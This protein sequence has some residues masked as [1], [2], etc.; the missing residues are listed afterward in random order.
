MAVGGSASGCLV[1][2]HCRTW[3]SGEPRRCWVRRP[4]GPGQRMRGSASRRE[5][6]SRARCHRPG[7]RRAHLAAARRRGRVVRSRRAPRPRSGKRI[8]RPG[9][10]ARGFASADGERGGRPPRR[11]PQPRPADQSPGSISFGRD[12]PARS[13]SP[14][15]QPGDVTLPL[16]GGG[17]RRVPGRRA[18]Q[19]RPRHDRMG[20]NP[21][22]RI[23]VWARETA[24]LTLQ[25]AVAKVGIRDARGVPAIDLSRDRGN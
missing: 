21:R 19:P 10:E 8:R 6:D 7:R 5:A 9:P 1:P 25:D 11:A 14:V 3:P 24:G 15:R 4:A 13:L 2:S 23:L 16:A 17:G 18:D 22:W 20:S 12:G